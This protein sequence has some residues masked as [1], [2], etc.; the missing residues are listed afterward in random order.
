L[1]LTIMNRLL[2][3][4]VHIAAHRCVAPSARRDGMAMRPFGAGQWCTAASSAA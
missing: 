4:M 3:T 2:L 1:L